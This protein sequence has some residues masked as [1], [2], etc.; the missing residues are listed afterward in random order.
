M[1]CR[2]TGTNSN[3]ITLVSAQLQWPLRAKSTPLTFTVIVLTD[4]VHTLY[5]TNTHT[6]KVSRGAE[7]VNPRADS[8][9]ETGMR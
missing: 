7:Q 9:E 6:E 3:L 5:K 2:Q 1:A 4:I 8:D